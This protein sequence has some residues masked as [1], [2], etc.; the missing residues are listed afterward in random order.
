MIAGFPFPQAWTLQ[1]LNTERLC[2]ARTAVEVMGARGGGDAPSFS[3]SSHLVMTSHYLSRGPHCGYVI[4][5][6]SKRGQ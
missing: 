5:V 3:I 1:S 2:K 6:M 4:A